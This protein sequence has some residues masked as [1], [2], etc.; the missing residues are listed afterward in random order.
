MKLDALGDQIEVIIE[1]DMVEGTI[2][3]CF[4]GNREA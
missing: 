3:V 4:T 2:M 1:G